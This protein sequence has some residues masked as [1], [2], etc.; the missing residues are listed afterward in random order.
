MKLDLILAGYCC[1]GLL[2]TLGLSAA[3]SLSPADKQ[4]LVLAAQT[5]M[6]EAHKGQMAESQAARAD[7]KKFANTLV[8]DHTK[9]YQ[10]VRELA[11]KEGVSIPQ[12]INIAKNKAIEELIRLSGSRF[13]QQFIRYE[14]TDHRRAIAVFKREANRGQDP[15]VRAYA[16]KM[17]P[18][19]EAHLQL[20]QKCAKP[21][22]RS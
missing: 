1:F 4:F 13:D 5:D 11:V 3:T 22:A 6:T 21:I 8:H 15:E 17:V 19:L 9:S 7:L 16:A 18:I 2:G 20:A 12:G 14:I 10:Q